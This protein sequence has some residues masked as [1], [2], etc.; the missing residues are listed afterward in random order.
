MT[1]GFESKADIDV[2]RDVDNLIRASR[3][4]TLRVLGWS[5]HK[6][7]ERIKSEIKMTRE[8]N[9]VDGLQS[10]HDI[11]NKLILEVGS[12]LGG[13]VVQLGLSGAKA[14]GIEPSREYAIITQKR[15]TKYGLKD[16]CQCIKAPG[17]SLPFH[18]D[19]FDYVICFSV[20]EHTNNPYSVIKE[21]IRV[22]K[23]NGIILIRTEN[24]FSFWDAHYRMLWFPLMPKKLA[25][26]YLRLRG[27]D[28]YF[29][30]NYI[31]YTTFFSLQRYIN[32]LGNVRDLTRNRIEQTLQNPESIQ[33]SLKRF[34]VNTFKVLRLTRTLSRLIYW[35]LFLRNIM[36]PSIAFDLKKVN[37]MDSQ[38]SEI[39]DINA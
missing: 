37:D 22:T 21:I 7:E 4:P 30:E 6:V 18:D 36:K 34:V 16:K 2:A 35:I 19:T 20:L 39:D 1:K 5:E 23:P 10:H 31:T 17:E 12:G 13:F 27:R 32:K 24:Y 14:I 33:S 28:P 11:K 25:K 15:I 9:F 26:F 38:I 3:G 29:F 8:A